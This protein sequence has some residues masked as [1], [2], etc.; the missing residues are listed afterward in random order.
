MSAAE[1]QRDA[2]HYPTLYKD[3]A[4][5]ETKYYRIPSANADG[6]VWFRRSSHVQLKRENAHHAPLLDDLIRAGRDG[7]LFF[8][9][10]PAS[11]SWVQNLLGFTSEY[12]P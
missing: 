11:P 12:E 3:L 4:Y 2:Q 8:D 9:P 7:R 10:Q 6:W 5:Y 1:M